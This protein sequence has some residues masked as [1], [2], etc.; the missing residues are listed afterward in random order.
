MPSKASG[1]LTALAAGLGFF[2]SALIK[3]VSD[4]LFNRIA[5]LVLF[6]Y[7]GASANRSSCVIFWKLNTGQLSP[8]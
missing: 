7:S 1:L 2:F 8:S 4:L 5:R 3:V 6:F